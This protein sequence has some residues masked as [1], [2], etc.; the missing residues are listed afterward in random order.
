MDMYSKIQERIEQGSSDQRLLVIDETRT[1]A[2]GRE[3]RDR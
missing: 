2:C 3:I 1:E